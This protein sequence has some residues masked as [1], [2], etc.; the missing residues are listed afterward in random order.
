[1][2]ISSE[3]MMI[4][5]VRAAGTEAHSSLTGKKVFWNY[6]PPDLTPSTSYIANH[7]V[8][9]AQK[10]LIYKFSLRQGDSGHIGG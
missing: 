2:L 6:P 7:L 1:V 3:D 9:F 8:P 5:F 4:S 10:S